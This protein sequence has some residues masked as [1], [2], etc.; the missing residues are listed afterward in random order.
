MFGHSSPQDSMEVHQ[1]PQQPAE[2]PPFYLQSFHQAQWIKTHQKRLPG[3][4]QQPTRPTQQNPQNFQA[5]PPP[6]HY[7]ANASPQNRPYLHPQYVA[8][9]VFLQNQEKQRRHQQMMHQ[10]MIRMQKYVDV[11]EI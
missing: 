9:Q 1:V 6:L 8:Q 10:N 2:L 11:L 3:Q 4:M 5:E 7:P